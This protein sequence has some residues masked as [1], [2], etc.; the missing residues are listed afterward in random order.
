MGIPTPPSM[1]TYTCIE[2]PNTENLD[3]I[4]KASKI[5]KSQRTQLI[6]YRNELNNG[7]HETE[8]RQKKE[9]GRLTPDEMKSVQGFK[10][11]VRK[12]LMNDKYIDIDMV[13]ALP[14][15]LQK[16]FRDN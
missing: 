7:V 8:F 1:N 9:V 6:Q 12:A 2:K 10:R 15:I 11:D 13:N 4:I 3:K 5:D 14:I 16:I